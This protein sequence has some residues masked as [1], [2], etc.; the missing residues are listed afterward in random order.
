[1][2]SHVTVRRLCLTLLFAATLSPVVLSAQDVEPVWLLVERAGQLAEEGRIGEAIG[3]LLRADE[4]S[5]GRPETLVALGRAYKAAGDF[6]VAE[7]QLLAAVSRRSSF[8][9]P[10]EALVAR[11]ELADVYRSRR[12][13]ARYEQQLYLILEEDPVPPQV[14]LPASLGEAVA[15][16]GL[17]RTLV[18]YRLELQGSTLAR[19]M[20]AELTVG[21]GRYRE[22]ADLAAV[23]VVQQ[24]TA[25]VEALIDRDPTFEFRSV[26]NAVDLADGYPETRAYLA[27][28][29]LYHDLYYLA[30]ALWGRA[31]PGA[32]AVWRLLAGL[33]GSGTWGQRA[34]LQLAD[35]QLEPL[36]IEVR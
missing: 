31:D 17:D 5:P 6:A 34:R 9:V 29:R 23:A 28:D 14:I 25:L 21:L 33:P 35:P 4:L 1:M 7:E 18:L 12:D 19:G 22:A 30:A 10:A 15:S 13:F 27:E 2:T 3:T 8:R 36:L 20:L 26:E 32:L 11:Y 16:Q 24:M